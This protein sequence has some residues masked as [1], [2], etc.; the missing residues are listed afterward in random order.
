MIPT[1]LSH[2]GVYTLPTDPCSLQE[3][4]NATD[5]QKIHPMF[6]FSSSFPSSFPCLATNKDKEHK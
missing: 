1:F 2:G 5:E 6:F 4:R 3:E